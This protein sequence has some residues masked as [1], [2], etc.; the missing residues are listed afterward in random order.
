MDYYSKIRPF[1]NLLLY[2]TW[3]GLPTA[4]KTLYTI[5]IMMFEQ[6]VKLSKY[7]T[8]RIGGPAKYLCVVNNEQDLLEALNFAL[9]KSLTIL[10]LGKGSNTVFTD[11]GYNGLVIINDITG[12]KLDTKNSTIYAGAGEIWDDVVELAVNNDLIGIESLSLIPGTIGASPV[13]NIGA[14]GQELKDTLYSIRAYDTHLKSFVEL[15][16]IDCDFS[17]RNSI[18]KSKYYGRYIITQVNLKLKPYNAKHYT[19]PNYPSLQEEL[20]KISGPIKPID[21]RNAVINVRTSKL[22]DPAIIANTGSFFKNPI[23]SKKL[24]DSLKKVYP[25]MPV[26]D[27]GF[28]KKLAAGWLI[29]KA[30][31]KGYEKNG[32]AIHNKQALVITNQSADSFD[33]LK[34]IIDLVIKSVNDKFG[35]K[36]EPEP[37]II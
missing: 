27:F 12:L 20:N 31:L 5:F 17:Y 35:V 14:Y 15:K 9:N 33:D 25:D 6:N 3:L 32:I 24:A 10:V 36:L 19:P 2:N 28:N 23:V 8:M 16:N 29:E 22:P 1:N 30:G 11:T 37:E 26:Y 34:Y 4:R 7:D 18:F 21:V 13:N